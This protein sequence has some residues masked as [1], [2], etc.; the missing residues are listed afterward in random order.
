MERRNE[1]LN[2]RPLHQLAGQSGAFGRKFSINSILTFL[3][4][5][6]NFRPISGAAG[7]GRAFFRVFL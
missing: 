4:G 2:R 3:I 6:V 1:H 7:Q 5:S